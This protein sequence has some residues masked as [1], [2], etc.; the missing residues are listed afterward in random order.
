MQIE[1]GFGRPASGV[2]VRIGIAENAQR[3]VAIDADNLAAVSRDDNADQIAQLLKQIG[4][5][6]WLHRRGNAG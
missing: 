1:R 6:F 5:E 4:V 3:P 2:L